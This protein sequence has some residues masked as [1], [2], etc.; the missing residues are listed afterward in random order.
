M[1]N[2]LRRCYQHLFVDLAGQRGLSAQ[3]GD[4]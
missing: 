4:Y 1:N 3:H 2:L